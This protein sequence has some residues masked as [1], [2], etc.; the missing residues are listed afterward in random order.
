MKSLYKYTESFQPSRPLFELEVDSRNINANKYK[1]LVTF[2]VTP[3]QDDYL[4]QVVCTKFI[5]EWDNKTFTF[6]INRDNIVQSAMI[7][8]RSKLALF[9]EAN[10]DMRNPKQSKLYKWVRYSMPDAEWFNEIV[11]MLF[12]YLRSFCAYSSMKSYNAPA[13][14]QNGLLILQATMEKYEK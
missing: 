14:T 3:L 4:S 2:P 10:L 9:V 1:P 5:E 11:L 6:K 7:E 12:K 8:I 13:H